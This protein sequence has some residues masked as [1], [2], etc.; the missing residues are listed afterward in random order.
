[1]RVFVYIFSFIFLSLHSKSQTVFWTETFN[2]GCAANCATFAG[3]A[4]NGAWTFAANGANGAAPNKWFVSCAE[5]GMPVGACGAPC[6]AN[7]TLHIGSDPNS[8]CGCLICPTGDCGAAYDAC[9]GATFCGLSPLSNQ[10]AS[11]P[12]ISTVGKTGIS[13]SFDYIENGQG[14]A[15]DGIA[16]YSINGGAAWVILVNNAKTATGCGGQGIWANYTSAALPAT[17]DN[18]ANFRLS[19]TW[20]NN[21]DG[22]GTD[23][24]Y[25]INDLKVRY[26]VIL[27]IELVEFSAS[28]K[29]NSVHL[30]WTTA[31]EKNSDF[32]VI[33]K[34]EDGISF[35]DIA[36]VKASKNSN[37]NKNYTYNDNGRSGIV[38]YYRLKSIDLDESFKYSETVAVNTND[39]LSVNEM[40]FLNTEKNL[41]IKRELVLN[42]NYES[43]SLVNLEGKILNTYL[44]PD[45]T[46]GDK[47]LIPT[48]T[49]SQGLYMARFNG[50]SSQ[51]SFKFFISQ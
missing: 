48:N 26:N 1:M 16:Y 33:E 22:A 25:A 13:V 36:H 47:I 51:K 2:N 18:N 44:F 40:C 32:F 21:I 17:C 50:Y 11:S 24:S 14:A 42:G 39:N 9:N 23:P 8:D 35:N 20:V 19:F 15:D 4:G 45:F 46:Y 49:L 27:P 5:N 10:R 6:G 43:V 38:N 28:E 41:E 29:N 3:T 12:L 34:S 7:A 31:S 30:K 37:T